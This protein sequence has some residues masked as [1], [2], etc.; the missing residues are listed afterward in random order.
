MTSHTVKPLY[1]YWTLG[2]VLTLHGAE[3]LLM[4]NPLKNLLPVDEFLPIMF[5]AH[6]KYVTSDNKHEESHEKEPKK[7]IFIRI[8]MY[9]AIA[10]A[11]YMVMHDIDFF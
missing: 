4:A 10:V 3:K 6:P 2:Y 8:C 1:S 5:N 9:S 11:A 7:I